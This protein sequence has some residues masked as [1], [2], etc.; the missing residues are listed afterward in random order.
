MSEIVGT[1]NA[2]LCVCPDKRI[3]VRENEKRL[4]IKSQEEK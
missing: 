1:V 3:N 2:G 4:T